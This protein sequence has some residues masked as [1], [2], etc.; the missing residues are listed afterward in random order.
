MLSKLSIFFSHRGRVHRR[1]ALLEQPRGRCVAVSPKKAEGLPLQEGHRDLQLQ[2]QQ[3]DPRRQDEP[4]RNYFRFK[5]I[6]M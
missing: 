1:E 5:S 4:S 3:Q 2:L 6:S